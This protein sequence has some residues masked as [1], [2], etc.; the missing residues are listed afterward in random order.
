MRTMI[1][2]AHKIDKTEQQRL[3]ALAR[4]K[5]V[6][7]AAEAI[8]DDITLLA[9]EICDVPIALISLVEQD[10]Q[11]FKSV[12]GL[13]VSE[14]SRAV[15]FCAHSLGGEETLLVADSLEDVRFSN[16]PLVTGDPNIRFYAGA[17]LRTPDGFNLGT[18][19]VIDRKP[20]ELSPSKLMALEALARL[21]MTQLELRLAAIE[22]EQSAAALRQAEKLAVVGRLASSISHEI[23]NPLQAV[24]NLLYVADQ[25]LPFETHILLVQAQTELARVAQ[26]V[27]Q[28][29]RFHKQSEN[30]AA[31]ML[32]GLVEHVLG[33]FRSRFQTTGVLVSVRDRSRKRL[34]C[35]ANDLR[36]VIA[37][38]ISNALDAMREGGT[39][40]IRIH[41]S[42][43]G[44][45]LTIADNGVGMSREAQAR[46]FEAFFT[47]KGIMGNGL[48]LWV[49]KEVLDKHGARIAVR[50]TQGGNASGTV[51]RI[52]LPE[53]GLQDDPEV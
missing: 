3:A 17:P 33:L 10:R 22:E 15:S 52:V 45:V 39:L 27:T 9:A 42:A 30:A 12:V 21:V 29:L 1:S 14:T 46:M 35:Y 40:M 36:Q 13:P 51:F 20:R 41:D 4:Y 34:L 23:N 37:N 49:T 50:S 44:T 47:T 43:E 53:D 32:G 6:D 7:T 19:C 48:G 2:Q 11:W 24:T 25:N 38:L 5:I 26:V 28:T 18:L 16:N 8:Y 31:V